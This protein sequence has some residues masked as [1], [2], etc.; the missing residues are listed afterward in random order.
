MNIPELT[1]PKFQKLAINLSQIA[2]NHPEVGE[3][4]TDKI[5]R[6][7]IGRSLLCLPLLIENKPLL[8]AGSGVG[9]PGLIL[10]LSRPDMQFFLLEPKTR[11][12]G[13]IRWL[14]YQFEDLDNFETLESSL[15]EANFDSYPELQVTSRAALDW[16][17]LFEHLPSSSQPIIRWSSPSL[18]PD[19]FKNNIY[20]LRI[21]VNDQ[22]ISQV[23]TWAGTNK[24]FHVKHNDFEGA[25]NIEF[26][27]LSSPQ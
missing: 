25:S 24:M 23:F 6:N 10:A 13:I 26:E 17:E 20:L 18:Q 19:N 16:S 22:H 21:T 5:L 4:D 12:H 7:L 27:I 8:D 3:A 9:I 1:L 15:Q 14:A 11:C 2:R